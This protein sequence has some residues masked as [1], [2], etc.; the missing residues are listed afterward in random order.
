MTEGE[1]RVAAQ[2]R[3]KLAEE[4]R[5]RGDVARII[6]ASRS[7]ASRKVNGHVPFTIEDLIAIAGDLGLHPAEF[8][9]NTTAGS[10]LPSE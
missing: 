10:F 3:A 2:V 1:Q 9:T 6:G 7:A 5:R 4:N 8:F